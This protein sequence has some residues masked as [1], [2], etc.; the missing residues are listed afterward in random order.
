MLTGTCMELT[1]QSFAKFISDSDSGQL[2]RMLITNH[3]KV[4]VTLH[5]H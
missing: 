5:S 2:T 1:N 4:S 3:G